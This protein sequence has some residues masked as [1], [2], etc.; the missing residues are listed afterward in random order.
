MKEE[1]KEE[2]D[3]GRRGD[4]EEG[5]G[6][7]GRDGEG[8]EAAVGRA[9]GRRKKERRVRGRGLRGRNYETME[10]CFERQLRSE[11]SKGRSIF[12]TRAVSYYISIRP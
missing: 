10:V 7:R 6:G 2:Q 8:A 1:K 12:Q 9:K 4:E 11:G 5:Q 3:A